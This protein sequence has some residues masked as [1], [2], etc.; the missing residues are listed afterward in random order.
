MCAAPGH[1]L[2]ISEN[3]LARVARQKN[4]NI[5]PTKNALIL[6]I[7]DANCY[8]MVRRMLALLGTNR[9]EILNLLITGAFGGDMILGWH[10]FTAQPGKH[11]E[12]RTHPLH[13]PLARFQLYLRPPYCDIV[14]SIRRV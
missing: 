14:C 2:Q 6:P 12:Q 13:V 1:L 8:E 10:A 11:A 3:D 9:L 4:R 5:D 7:Q